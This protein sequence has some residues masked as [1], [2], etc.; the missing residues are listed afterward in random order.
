V[1]VLVVT[2][3]YPGP[4]ATQRGRFVYDQ[5]EA[6]RALPDVD[7]ELFRFQP[8]ARN[9]V[10]ATRSLRRLLRRER[11]DLVHAHYGL[12]G[13]CCAAAGA[14]PLA[15][16][17]HGTDV[18]HRAVGPLSR[19]LQHRIELSAGVSSGLFTR[20]SGRAGL[21]ARR[22]VAVLPCGVDLARFRPASRAEARRRLGLDEAGR[23]LLF[24]ADPAR[25]GKRHDRATEV[26][27]MADAELLTAGTVDPDAMP[28]WVNAANAVLVPSEN[29]GFGLAMLEALACDVPVLST[30]VGIA[31][32]A[33]RGVAGCLVAPFDA[34]AWAEAA[35]PALADADARIEGRDRAA[36]FSATLMAERVAAAYRELATNAAP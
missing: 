32:H 34:E 25:P 4:G 33:L 21:G 5:V 8:G 18:R 20:E 31:P 26:A 3:L 12:T 10:P 7:L 1:R 27:R 19:R 6:L 36:R 13:W 28:D 15:V 29:E 16:T 35:A 11:Y 24:P 17:F 2:N 30:P 23:Y 9:Y 22:K 14:R